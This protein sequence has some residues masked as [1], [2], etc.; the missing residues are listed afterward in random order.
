MIQVESTLIVHKVSESNAPG[1]GENFTIAIQSHP[2]RAGLIVLVVGDQK[3]SIVAADAIAAI[4]N[5]LNNNRY[6]A[7]G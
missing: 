4:N 3:Y 6:P 7:S 1:E 2:I 5:A